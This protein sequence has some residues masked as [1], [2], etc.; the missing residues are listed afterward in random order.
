[1]AF[2]TR[3]LVIPVA[4]VLLSACQ[5][6]YKTTDDPNKQNNQYAGYGQAQGNVPAV[7]PANRNNQPTTPS[8]KPEP[9]SNPTPGSGEVRNTS[10]R[11]GVVRTQPVATRRAPPSEGSGEIESHT[12]T[13]SNSPSWSNGNTSGAATGNASSSHSDGTPRSSG[14]ATA[15]TVAPGSDVVQVAATDESTGPCFCQEHNQIES[16]LRTHKLDLL[17]VVDG[18]LSVKER[19]EIANNI[20][21]LIVALPKN[22]DLRVGVLPAHGSTSKLSGVLYAPANEQKVLNSS[23]MAKAAAMS[24][25]TIRSTL[26][27]RMVSVPADSGTAGKGLTSLSKALNGDNEF[28]NLVK[29]GMHRQDAGLAVILVGVANDEKEFKAGELFKRLKEIKQKMPLT[30]NGILASGNSIN[31]NQKGYGY[32]ELVKLANGNVIPLNAAVSEGLSEIGENIHIKLYSELVFPVKYA[33]GYNGENI[34]VYLDGVKQPKSVG[35]YNQETRKFHVHS[36]GCVNARI[37]IEYCNK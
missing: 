29:E 14:S 20:D 1:M 4:A 7:P 9:I 27:E 19:E 12:S 18:R 28:F 35:F 13:G 8:A 30:V 32:L 16:V 22:M 24:M 26:R 15:R 17:F 2:L 36:I 23:P 31:A 21:D 6:Q 5:A 25:S 11:G 37:R 34:T 3:F 10:D 33:S